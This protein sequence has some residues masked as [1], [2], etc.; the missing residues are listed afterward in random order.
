MIYI[1]ISF[2]IVRK[3]MFEIYDIFQFPIPLNDIFNDSDASILTENPR[4]FIINKEDLYFSLAD[5][6]SNF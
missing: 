3:K 5:N 1:S 6:K 2:P 4:Y